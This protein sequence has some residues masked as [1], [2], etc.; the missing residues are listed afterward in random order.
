MV[1][2]SYDQKTLV[3]MDLFKPADTKMRC[4]FLI[5]HDIPGQFQIGDICITQEY[6]EDGD[7]SIPIGSQVLITDSEPETGEVL[8]K[9]LEVCWDAVYDDVCDFWEGCDYCNGEYD[10]DCDCV[11][12]ETDYIYEEI[13]ES[14]YWF[15][16]DAL[17]PD[18]TLEYESKR[19]RRGVKIPKSNFL[20]TPTDDAMFEEAMRQ[21][22]TLRFHKLSKLLKQ[23]TR[24]LMAKVSGF[25][26]KVKEW[27][28][29]PTAEE[30][31]EWEETGFISH[32]RASRLRSRF[33][34]QDPHS[35]PCATAYEGLTLEKLNSFIGE[36]STSTAL[37]WTHPM[38]IKPQRPTKWSCEVQEEPVLE[39]VPHNPQ[40]EWKECAEVPVEEEHIELPF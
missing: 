22:K 29:D 36:I 7:W 9:P 18:I 34:Y 5:K 28:K 16:I 35:N 14:R 37:T 31:L 24:D 23:K 13:F 33:G 2:Q 20:I 8:V 4:N 21:T 40:T 3:L 1:L 39:E 19:R 30:I 32:K 27:F 10:E 12:T 38:V 6:N 25:F 15:P 11:T 17:K 26:K